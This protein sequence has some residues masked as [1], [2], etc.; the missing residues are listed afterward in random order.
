MG[1]FVSFHLTDIHSLTKC[2]YKPIYYIS[3]SIR[4]PMD[5]TENGVASLHTIRFTISCYVEYHISSNALYSP[6]TFT[7]CELQDT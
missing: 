2:Q 3:S 5:A 1:L 4:F 6:N 7:S